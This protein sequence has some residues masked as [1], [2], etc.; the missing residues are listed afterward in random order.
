MLAKLPASRT[1][2]GRQDVSGSNV[3]GSNQVFK[4]SYL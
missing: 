4:T 1:A 2:G 3:S